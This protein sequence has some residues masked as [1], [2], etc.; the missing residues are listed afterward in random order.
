MTLIDPH[1]LERQAEHRGPTWLDRVADG[2]EDMSQ[3][4]SEGFGAEV[5]HAWKQREKTLEKLGLGERGRDGFEMAPGWRDSLTAL[6]QEALRD[7]I[8]RDTGRVAHF[9][10]GGERV[11]GL[12]TGR[13]HMAEQS[14][15]LIEHDR[16]ATLAPWRPAMD[17]AL[18]QFVAGQVNG[19]NFDFKYGRGVEKEITKMLGID[20]GGR[21]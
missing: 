21:G 17:R 15:A 6:E 13:I 2:R 10:R 19:I 12:Y 9:A 8:E 14:F 3:M 20:I 4:R 1:A 5:G 18:N 16:T 7:R 11:H